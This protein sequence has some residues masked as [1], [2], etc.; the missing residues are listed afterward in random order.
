MTQEN[1]VQHLTATEPLSTAPASVPDATRRKRF[2][3]VAACSII[4]LVCVGTLPR[5]LLRRQLRSQASAQATAAA[6][7]FVIPAQ[8]YQ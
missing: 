8:P 5:L 4:V 7:V 6:N 1:E 3:L 2:L